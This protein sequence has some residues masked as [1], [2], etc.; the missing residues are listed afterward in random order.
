MSRCAP[1]W[2]PITSEQ[3]KNEKKNHLSLNRHMLHDIVQKSF[4]VSVPLCIGTLAYQVSGRRKL[5]PLLIQRPSLGYESH[6]VAAMPSSL[7]W[8]TAD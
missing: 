4:I 3:R 7:V 5:R 6:L 8:I 2:G 1:L